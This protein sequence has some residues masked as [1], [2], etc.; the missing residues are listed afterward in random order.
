[1]SR[2]FSHF[3][4][5]GLILALL[6]SATHTA[7]GETLAREGAGWLEDIDGYL[8]LHLEGTHHEMG[9][10]HGK[11]LREHIRQNVQFLVHEKGEESV[12]DVGPLG[13]TP[14]QIIPQIER[15]DVAITD[16]AARGDG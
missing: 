16:I 5:M 12:A 2:V 10:Q 13:I 11:L 6:L 1:M 9:V 15:I 8:V 14:R 4:L 7:M 3:A